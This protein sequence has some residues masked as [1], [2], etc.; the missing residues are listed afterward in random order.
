MDEKDFNPFKSELVSFSQPRVTFT[1]ERF[2]FNKSPVTGADNTTPPLE[3]SESDLQALRNAEPTFSLQS[4]NPQ[5][6]GQNENFQIIDRQKDFRKPPLNQ[7]SSESQSKKGGTGKVETKNVCHLGQ[8]A[9]QGFYV[10]G[11]PQPI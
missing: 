10:D 9:T 11:P 8:P 5:T 4:T 6:I 3:V 2:D 7:Q 1:K